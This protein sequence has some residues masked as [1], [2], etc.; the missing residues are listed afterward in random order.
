MNRTVAI[1][2]W[3]ACCTAT[4]A[5]ETGV[6]EQLLSVNTKIPPTQLSQCIAGGLNNTSWVG[7]SSTLR[8]SQEQSGVELQVRVADTAAT[9]LGLYVIR[10]GMLI[11]YAFAGAVNREQATTLVRIALNCIRS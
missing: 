7:S 6:R 5:A 4:Q 1:V 11:A 9:N 3:F 10:D 2:F 8:V